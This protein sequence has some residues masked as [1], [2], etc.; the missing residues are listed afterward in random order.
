[1]VGGG[2]NHPVAS[3]VGGAGTGTKEI[4]DLPLIFRVGRVEDLGPD[5]KSPHE[6]SQAKG[7]ESLKGTNG[8]EEDE[9]SGLGFE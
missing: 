9:H 6:G 3:L 4:L 7:E 8:W 2:A 5:W 1:M